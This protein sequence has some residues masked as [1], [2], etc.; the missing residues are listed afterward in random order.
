MAKNSKDIDNLTLDVL[1]AEEAGMS[2]GY[3]KAMTREPDKK[4]ERRLPKKLDYEEEPLWDA[5]CVVCGALF[6]KRT[7]NQKTC[8][9]RCRDIWNRSYAK[10]YQRNK[11]VIIHHE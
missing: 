4:V 8:S 9:E 1:A 7:W 6:R 2:Y 3:Y 10:N 5:A 11:T